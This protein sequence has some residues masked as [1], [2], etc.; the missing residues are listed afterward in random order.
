MGARRLCGENDQLQ[1]C[2]CEELSLFFDSKSIGQQSG[3]TSKAVKTRSQRLHRRWCH[4]YPGFTY[5]PRFP[6]QVDVPYEP[7]KVLMVQRIRCLKKKPYWDKNIMTELGLNNTKS[8]IA[9][10]AN[11]P[12]VNAL[13]W[14]VKHLIK[15]TP[16]TFPNGIPDDGDVRGARL[17][18]NGELVFVPKLAKDADAL[19][20]ETV[21]K[22]PRVDGETMQKYLRAKWMKPWD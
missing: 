1:T 17:R 22:Q 5:Y 13:L 3:G 11:T 18:E 14:K 12:P 16:V 9:I 6:E 8:T 4:V 7:S 15:I 19:G 10:V 2:N 20:V 21:V